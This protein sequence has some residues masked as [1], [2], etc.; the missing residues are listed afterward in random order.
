MRETLKVSPHLAS[1]IRTFCFTWSLGGDEENCWYDEK[2]GS[3]LDIAFI[4]RLRWWDDL[5]SELGCESSIAI[6]HPDGPKLFFNYNDVIHLAP[7]YSYELSETDDGYPTY[8]IPLPLS[9]EATDPMASVRTASSR[10]QS[11]SSTALA[12]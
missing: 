11:S 9:S 4:D 1:L 12:R 3:L 5:R 2:A 6:N 8:T 7:G 10:T